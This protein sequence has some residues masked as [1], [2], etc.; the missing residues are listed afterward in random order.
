MTLDLATTI[1]PVH[2][3]RVRLDLPETEVFAYSKWL[4]EAE[5]ERAAKFLS[6]HKTR[7]FMI[8]RGTLK[9]KLA[10]MLGEDITQVRISHEKD[11]R[12]CLDNN[13]HGIRFSVSHSFDRAM[14]AMTRGRAIGIDLEK[15]RTDIDHAGLSRRF[16]SPAEH[17]A[18][19]LCD[20]ATRIRAFF[21][22]WTRKEAIVKA[23]GKG[24]A[25][26]LSQFDVSVD[27]DQPPRL[28]A[29]RWQLTDMPD[30]TLQ[31]LN[32]TAGYAA[33]LAVSGGAVSVVYRDLP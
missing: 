10:E 32:A 19:Q 12:P 5:Q 2:I 26:G 30:W 16:F 29:T 1:E 33:S 6:A 8:T 18:L 21:A 31:T 22:V 9:M 7:E 11:G 3:Y 17:S 15:I 13:K 20:E 27:P 14:I 25:L 24:I 4:S 23:H 28:L